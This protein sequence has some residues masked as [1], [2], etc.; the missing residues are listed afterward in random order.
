[1]RLQGILGTVAI[2]SGCLFLWPIAIYSPMN[3]HTLAHT[4]THKMKR[5]RYQMQKPTNRLTPFITK[6]Q[7]NRETEVVRNWSE[8]PGEMT[9]A[10]GK[11]RA[12]FDWWK[13]SQTDNDGGHITQWAHQPYSQESA[14]DPWVSPWPYEFHNPLHRGIDRAVSSWLHAAQGLSMTP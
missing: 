6:R 14:E 1:M 5:E 12:S 7:V 8:G 4:H 2:T 10:I 13:C 11:H 9:L 3:T